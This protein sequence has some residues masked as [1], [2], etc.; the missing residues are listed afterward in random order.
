MKQWY[1]TNLLVNIGWTLSAPL[2]WPLRIYYRNK[3]APKWI[4]WWGNRTDNL[5]DQGKEAV[6]GMRIPFTN[7]QINISFMMK[8]R[9]TYGKFIRED[10]WYD[11]LD[12]EDRD[13]FED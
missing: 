5:W 1:D 13:R 9:E 10:K 4:R 6:H 3:K 12:P 8:N 7:K 11:N 2:Y